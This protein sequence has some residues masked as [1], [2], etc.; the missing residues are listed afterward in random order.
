MRSKSPV[1]GREYRRRKDGEID[2]RAK[3]A[4]DGICS[5]GYTGPIVTSRK[6]GG[7]F[8]KRC[9]TRVKLDAYV[10]RIGEDAHSE[11]L[12]SWSKANRD[13]MR[14]SERAYRQRRKAADP[15]YYAA[16]SSAFKKLL[17]E[18]K[19]AWNI[20]DHN[21]QIHEFYT[22]RPE[23]YHVDHIV[24]LRG[25]NVC[26]LHVIWNLQYLPAVENM[27]KSNKVRSC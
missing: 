25:D 22:N 18:R 23:G 14:Q 19:P 17:R 26:G 11:M 8:C 20:P 27:K 12:K 2:G 1:T 10:S 7:S 13:K 9:Y 6:Y 4:K 5:C 16:R 21:K 3:Q 24:P 15:R